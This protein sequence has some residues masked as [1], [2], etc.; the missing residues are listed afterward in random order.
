MTS[1]EGSDFQRL[2]TVDPATGRLH[3]VVTGINWD[4]TGFDIADDGSFIAF[5][6]N[7]A[8]ASRL[9]LL[10]TQD[11]ARAARSNRSPPG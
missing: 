9:R 5:V 6:T 3:A 11:A 1:D 10:D 2:G 4:V 8:G 7:E